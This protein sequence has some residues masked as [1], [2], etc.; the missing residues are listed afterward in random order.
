MRTRYFMHDP[1]SS[2][3]FFATE[4][5]ALAAAA[6]AIE[7]R[8]QLNDEWPDDIDEI[9]VGMVTHVTRQANRVDRPADLDEHGCTPDGE[10]WD[11]SIDY[12]CDYVMQAIQGETDATNP[13]RDHD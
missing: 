1:E 5:G 3:E 12:T 7:M 11:R 13:T 8:R 10:Y 6:A 2:P 4:A 9:Y